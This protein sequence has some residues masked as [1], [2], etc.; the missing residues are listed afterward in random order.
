MMMM[1]IT[2]HRKTLKIKPKLNTVAKH[3]N[4]GVRSPFVLTPRCVVVVVVD[5]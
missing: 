2:S 3:S 5:I 1:M 4:S